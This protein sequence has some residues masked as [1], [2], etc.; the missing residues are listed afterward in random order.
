MTAVA[1]CD[2]AERKGTA[3]AGGR[4]VPFGVECHYVP[5]L[6]P[7]GCRTLAARRAANRGPALVVL[8]CR[9]LHQAR[10]PAVLEHIIKPTVLG[11]CEPDSRAVAEAL[12]YFRI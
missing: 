9:A 3:P 5:P 2:P 1:V 10:R 11:V 6:R 4:S 8:G 12:S 7:C